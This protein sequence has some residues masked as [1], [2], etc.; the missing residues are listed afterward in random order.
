M[1]LNNPILVGFGV[2]D[3]ASFELATRHTTGAII[4]SAYIK[5]LENSTDVSATTAQ[6]LSSIIGKK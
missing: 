2:K 6:F 3:A 1:Q 5:A 4:G